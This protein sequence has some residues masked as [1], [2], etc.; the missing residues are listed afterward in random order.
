M[1]W[2]LFNL[3]KDPEEGNIGNTYLQHRCHLKA[4]EHALGEHVLQ[5][6]SLAKG[7][8]K[9]SSF[10]TRWS[11]VQDEIRQGSW[12]SRGRSVWRVFELHLQEASHQ[13]FLNKT[14]QFKITFFS[15]KS[16]HYEKKKNKENWEICPF[17][18]EILHERLRRPFFK[19]SLHCS[20][21][22]SELPRWDAQPEPSFLCACQIKAVDNGRPQ[23]SS[24]ARLHIEWIKKPVPSPVPLTF[25]EPFYN[26]TVMESD[27]VTEI[28]GV[29][30]V[31]PSNIPLW[32]DIVGKS[33]VR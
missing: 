1:T 22:S 4:V 20:R 18:S 32:F 12:F 10:A 23:K 7:H 25:D 33:G 2:N 21:I 5:M 6:H 14:F 8:Y 9:A 30:S 11:W 15:E 24:T 29:V 19:Q 28:V 3:I 31:Q 27:K 26:F 13:H 16:K 17:F